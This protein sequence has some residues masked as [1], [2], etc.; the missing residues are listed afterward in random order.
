VL[1]SSVPAFVILS[2]FVI[3]VLVIRLLFHRLPIGYLGAM[4]FG[5]GIYTVVSFMRSPVMGDLIDFIVPAFFLL[6]GFLLVF[7]PP[8]PRQQGQGNYLRRLV[9]HINPSAPIS[10]LG[11]SWLLYRFISS[12]RTSSEIIAILV[13]VGLFAFLS[14]LWGRQAAQRHEAFQIIAAEKP[15]PGESPRPEVAVIRIYGDYLLAVPFNR[16][17][18]PKQFEKKLYILKLSDMPKIPLVLES[19]GPLIPKPPKP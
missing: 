15:A 11:A 12:Q 1:I 7:L 8:W 18:S 3:G 9:D 17:T 4:L 13:L 10:S 16:T 2:I 19:I 6:V 5:S 14:I